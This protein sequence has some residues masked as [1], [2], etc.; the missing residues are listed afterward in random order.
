MGISAFKGVSKVE[1]VSRA[2]G[3]AHAFQLGVKIRGSCQHGPLLFCRVG[4]HWW[5]EFNRLFLQVYYLL[6]K[7][8]H[9]ASIKATRSHV[10]VEMEVATDV[11]GCLDGCVALF[12]HYNP[13]FVHLDARMSLLSFYIPTHVNL[14]RHS[15]HEF[16]ACFIAVL[17]TNFAGTPRNWT[18]IIT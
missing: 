17:C 5:S 7:C 4:T 10:R 3:R 18:E 9:V 2:W 12:T 16:L 14:V 6:N 1:V 15:S 8:V 13:K 11:V